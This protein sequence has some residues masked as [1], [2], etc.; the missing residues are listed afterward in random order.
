[1]PPLLS[2]DVPKHLGPTDYRTSISVW[3]RHV[4]KKSPDNLSGLIEYDL[5]AADL[6]LSQNMSFIRTAQID[7]FLQNP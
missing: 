2:S 7:G 4:L 3:R 5:N 1:M 6:K